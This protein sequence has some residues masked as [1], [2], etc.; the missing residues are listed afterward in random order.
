M[1]RSS[2]VTLSTSQIIHRRILFMALNRIIAS[3]SLTISISGSTWFR[4]IARGMRLIMRVYIDKR[5]A[6]LTAP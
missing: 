4:V 5:I 1:I 3:N 2:P 6:V